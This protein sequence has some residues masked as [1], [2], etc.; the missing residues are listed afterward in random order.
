MKSWVQ[1]NSL[2]V[3]EDQYR[4]QVMGLKFTVKGLVVGV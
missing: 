2:K 1:D 3:T 4:L